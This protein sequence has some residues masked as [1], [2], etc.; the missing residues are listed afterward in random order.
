MVLLVHIFKR[1][2]VQIPPQNL[3]SLIGTFLD[4]LKLTHI[5]RGMNLY[6]KF[7]QNSLGDLAVL[8]P[9]RFGSFKDEMFSIQSLIGIWLQENYM[10]NRVSSSSPYKTGRVQQTLAVLEE[11]RVKLDTDLTP[12]Q[13]AALSSHLANVGRPLMEWFGKENQIIQLHKTIMEG[14]NPSITLDDIHNLVD[15]AF[16][17]DWA[18]KLAQTKTY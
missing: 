2:S 16:F 7:I 5:Y 1:S 6:M 9:P 14:K 13:Q 17:D 12:A 11:N 18:L 8:I 4:F 3:G 15:N 10:P